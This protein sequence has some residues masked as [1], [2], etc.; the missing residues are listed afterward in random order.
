MRAVWLLVLACCG[1]V[2]TPTGPR[3]TGIDSTAVVGDAELAIH[4]RYESLPGDELRFFVDLAAK[5]GDVGAIAV[6]LAAEGME[7]R[8]GDRRWSGSIAGGS[9]TTH[10]TSW[11]AVATRAP[12]ITVTTR[13]VEGDVELAKDVVRFVVD[14]G[15]VRECRPT[16]AA[17]E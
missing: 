9:T 5:S 8:S 2:E 15:T 6:D 11:H 10:T 13:R 1:G 7:L 16:D 4:Y 12:T 14:E 17:C 3:P